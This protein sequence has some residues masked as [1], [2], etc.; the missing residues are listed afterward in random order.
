MIQ[1]L[2]LETYRLKLRTLKSQIE[3]H[4]RLIAIFYVI[5]Q[6]FHAAR[7]LIYIVNKQA[8]WHIFQIDARLFWSAHLLS[9]SE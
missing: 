3:E 4:V 7:L 2:I 6:K 1:L 8:G 9:T 5:N